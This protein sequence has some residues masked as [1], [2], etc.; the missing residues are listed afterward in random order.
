M[1]DRFFGKLAV[2]LAIVLV[3][4][5]VRV[6][7]AFYRSPGARRGDRSRDRRA[8]SPQRISGLNKNVGNLFPAQKWHN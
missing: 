8:R 5:L 4:F 3:V 2:G 7:A 1:K 6:P